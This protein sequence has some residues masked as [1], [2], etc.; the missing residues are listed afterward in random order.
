MTNV[1]TSHVHFIDGVPKCEPLQYVHIQYSYL[2]IVN[3]NAYITF[4]EILSICSHDIE[5]KR[6]FSMSQGPYL[7]TVTGNNPD[8]DLV[9]INAHT[10]LI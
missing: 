2:D 8:L 7:R 9:N 1:I 3:M 5:R 4:G 10:N 6:N